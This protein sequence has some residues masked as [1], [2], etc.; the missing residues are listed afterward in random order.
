MCVCGGGGVYTNVCTVFCNKFLQL[1][2][3][4]DLSKMEVLTMC[5][6]EGMRVHAPVPIV[7]RETEGEFRI[8]DRVFPAGIVV[9]INI[10]V[11]NHMESVWGKDHWE[12]KPERFS[13]DN[14]AK[15][16]AYQFVPFSAGPRFVPHKHCCSST[17]LKLEEG[18]LYS[19]RC[20]R[21]ILVMV[22]I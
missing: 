2:F 3:R 1:C 7:N 10:W 14:C 6:K 5:I 20:R 19:H 16:A 18:I 8:K 15:M 21:H 12:F 13:K 17:I 9:Q 4:A 11:L 22:C